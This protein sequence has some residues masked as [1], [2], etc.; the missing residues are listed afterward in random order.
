MTWLTKYTLSPRGIV[1]LSVEWFIR[2]EN[3]GKETV[4]WCGVV[5][6]CGGWVV[7]RDWSGFLCEL[8]WVVLALYHPYNKKSLII[9]QWMSKSRWFHVQICSNL[10][11]SILVLYHIKQNSG[12]VNLEPPC[13][14][15]VLHYR[16]LMDFSWGFIWK[17]CKP[18]EAVWIVLS[19]VH[20]CEASANAR[21]RNFFLCFSCVCICA[22]FIIFQYE[23]PYN[24]CLLHKCE[25]GFSS[26][27]MM[28]Y[29]V[30]QLLQCVSMN[31]VIIRKVYRIN[32]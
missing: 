25:P 23:H 14:I 32:F 19:L 9:L 29:E 2:Q 5:V 6:Y 18:V 15:W 22:C 13:K 21:K 16:K 28:S 3:N 20:T 10:C 7:V 30:E 11:N 31:E 4:A 17:W 1:W 8:P 12:A 24:L 26:V 27:S